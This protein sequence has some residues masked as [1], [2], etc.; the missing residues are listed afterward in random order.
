MIIF[1]DKLHKHVGFSSQS[2]ELFDMKNRPIVSN[3]NFD[4][5]FQSVW[6][7]MSFLSPH[8]FFFRHE[9]TPFFLR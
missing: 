2:H 7:K 3:L 1:V 9:T 8:S 6:K 5:L 4:N